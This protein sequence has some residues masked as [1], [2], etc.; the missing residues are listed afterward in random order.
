MVAILFLIRLP[1]ILKSVI[2]CLWGALPFNITIL[3]VALKTGELE[4]IFLKSQA[5][6]TIH[7]GFPSLKVLKAVTF[8]MI[9][10]ASPQ[11]R[12]VQTEMI[13]ITEKFLQ[14]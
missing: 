8:L 6:E 1:L 14:F 10:I 4:L 9:L 12:K 3:N 5:P 7:A 13:P 2:V 11:I